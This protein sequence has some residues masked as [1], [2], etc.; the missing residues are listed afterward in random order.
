MKEITKYLEWYLPLTDF[1]PEELKIANEYRKRFLCKKDNMWFDYDLITG[2][3]LLNFHYDGSGYWNGGMDGLKESFDITDKQQ[4]TKSEFLQLI[5]EDEFVLPENWCVKCVGDHTLYPELYEWRRTLT[6]YT[7]AWEFGGFM[8]SK[9]FILNLAKLNDSTEITYDQFIEYIYNPKFKQTNTMDKNKQ[10]KIDRQLLNHYY[11]CATMSQRQYI[12]DNFKI[13]GTTTVGAI[14]G[15]HDIACSNWKPKIKENHPE[16][17]EA[18]KFDLSD[19]KDYRY[20]GKRMIERIQVNTDDLFH[21]GFWLNDGDFTWELKKSKG[22]KGGMLLIP[23][24][25]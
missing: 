13:D 14:V 16:C 19:F 24:R 2:K 11:E 21:Q 20:K 25:K 1:N 22:I 23:K 12:S 7:T 6:D 8:N 5:N 4:L 3:I 15:L 9:G 18:E 17:F 10:I